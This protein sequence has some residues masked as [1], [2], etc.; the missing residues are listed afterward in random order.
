MNHEVPFQVEH[1]IK[2]MLNKSENVHIRGNYKQ[3]LET[4][5]E[6]ID[7]AIRSY[8]NELFTSNTKKKRA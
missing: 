6:A 3:R 4:I 2:S 8:D 1:I 5:K 7:K